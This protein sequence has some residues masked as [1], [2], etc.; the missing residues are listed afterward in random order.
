MGRTKLNCHPQIFQRLQAVEGAR[1]DHGN[2]A[3]LQFPAQFVDV[4]R[5]VQDADRRTA[6]L[7][8]TV[9]LP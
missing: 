2:L 3:A 6:R 9:R 4:I 5:V 7:G 1:L 8:G